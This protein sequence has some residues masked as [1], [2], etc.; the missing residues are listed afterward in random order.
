MLFSWGEL[1][2][3]RLGG[4]ALVVISADGRPLPASEGPYALRSL[5]DIKS[6]PRHVKWLR[7]LDVFTAP[8]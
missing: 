7:Q 8:Q 2:N 6:G 1:F 4:S 3:A 5:S